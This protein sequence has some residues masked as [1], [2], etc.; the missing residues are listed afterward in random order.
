MKLDK[1]IVWHELTD[2]KYILLYFIFNQIIAKQQAKSP[3]IQLTRHKRKHKKYA[4]IYWDFQ[5]I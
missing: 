5:L 1:E 3:K 4:E 2:V